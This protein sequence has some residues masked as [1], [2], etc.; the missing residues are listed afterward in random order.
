MFLL[1]DQML[2]GEVVQLAK[3]F[4]IVLLYHARFA[5]ACETAGR[6]YTWTDEPRAPGVASMGAYVPLLKKPAQTFLC[7]IAYE[8][9]HLFNPSPYFSRQVL[10]LVR[11]RY[12]CTHKL[13]LVMLKTL[14]ISSDSRP[15][16]SRSVKTR[17]S[18]RERLSRHL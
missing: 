15:S 8:S 7:R 2:P 3:G 5:I 18:R 16:T 10:S 17:E 13:V 11:A 14:H 4:H 12:I 9:P 6:I 1:C